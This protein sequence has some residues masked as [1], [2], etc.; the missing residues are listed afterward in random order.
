MHPYVHSSTIHNSQDVG[1]ISVSTDRRMDTED[2][3]HI[4]NG[5][6]LGHKE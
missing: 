5:I 1:T 2:V 6:V 4:Y 3:V